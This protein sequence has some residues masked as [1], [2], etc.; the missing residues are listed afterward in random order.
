QALNYPGIEIEY[1]K[2]DLA[3]KTAPLAKGFPHFLFLYYNNLYYICQ[4][5]ENPHIIW[6]MTKKGTLVS[7]GKEVPYDCTSFRN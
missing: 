5:A 2:T 7:T 4:V 6:Y 1:L 3:P